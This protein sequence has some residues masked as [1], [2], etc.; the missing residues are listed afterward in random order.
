MKLLNELEA[1][2][3]VGGESFFEPWK[4]EWR[5]GRCVTLGTNHR[6]DKDKH[7]NWRNYEKTPALQYNNKPKNQCNQVYR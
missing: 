3:I 6:Y 7:G 1:G 4:D 2:T 5:D